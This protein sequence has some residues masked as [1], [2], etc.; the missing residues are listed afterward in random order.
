MPLRGSSIEKYHM[1]KSVKPRLESIEKS[2]ET[3]KD[4]EEIKKVL[5]LTKAGVD[6]RR[7]LKGLFKE[8]SKKEVNLN[9]YLI[10]KRK[11]K[12]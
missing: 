7:N 3:E 6:F 11:N 2:G 8:V 5:A 4:E 1:K 10:A 9:Q 12:F